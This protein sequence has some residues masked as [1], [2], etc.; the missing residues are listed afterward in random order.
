MDT[1]M[2]HTLLKTGRKRLSFGSLETPKQHR[3]ATVK[4]MQELSCQLT[5]IIMTVYS[6]LFCKTI[7]KKKKPFINSF[8]P[9]EL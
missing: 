3:L 8:C 2:D 1:V 5:K 7:H 9:Q 6:Q 4:G